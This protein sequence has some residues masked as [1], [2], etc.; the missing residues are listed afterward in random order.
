MGDEV[1]TVVVSE[2]GETD[3]PGADALEDPGEAVVGADEGAE[4]GGGGEEE[5]GDPLVVGGDPVEAVD[6]PTGVEEG[7]ACC[8]SD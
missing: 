3:V 5:E 7:D 1:T 6:G 2:E 8:D 4:E